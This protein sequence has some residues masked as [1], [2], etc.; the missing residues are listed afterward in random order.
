[1]NTCSPF[2]SQQGG[3][4]AVVKAGRTKHNETIFANLNYAGQDCNTRELSAAWARTGSGEE[5]NGSSNFLL[6]PVL[7][8]LSL[9]LEKGLKDASHLVKLL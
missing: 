5:K 1:M 4:T 7:D 8:F 2:K 9:E 3:E 6:A